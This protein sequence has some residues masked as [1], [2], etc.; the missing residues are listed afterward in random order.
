MS[1]TSIEEGTDL[2][3]LVGKA[4]YATGVGYVYLIGVFGDL[5]T[6]VFPR[7]ENGEWVTSLVTLDKS[8]VD[9]TFAYDLSDFPLWVEPLAAHFR[10]AATAGQNGTSEA[11]TADALAEAREAGKREAEERHERFMAALVSDA[12]EYAND[13][14]LCG[15]FDRFMEEHGLPRRER[16]YE[17]TFTITYSSTALVTAS[18]SDEAAEAL[19]ENPGAYISTEYVSLDSDNISVDDVWVA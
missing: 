10:E 5:I 11:P 9:N 17:V 12:H 8:T 2:S 7:R 15:E 3:T 14:D 1:Y 19:V 4:V 13:N 6:G 18:S 16:E